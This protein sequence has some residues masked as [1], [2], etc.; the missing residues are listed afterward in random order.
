MKYRVI[1]TVCMIGMVLVYGCGNGKDKTEDK[2][3][4]KKKNKEV[5]QKESPNLTDTDTTRKR[6]YRKDLPKTRADTTPYFADYKGYRYYFACGPCRDRFIQ[7]REKYLE[8]W[9]KKGR[10]IRK[11]KL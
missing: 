1:L 5:T 10:R 3:T 11:R 9:I 4:V 2:T 8:K 7:D 6:I